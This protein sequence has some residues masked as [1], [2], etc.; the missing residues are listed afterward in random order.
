M[1]NKLISLLE[2]FYSLALRYNLCI[3]N[4]W[5]N[6]RLPKKPDLKQRKTNIGIKILHIILDVKF[7]SFLR[8][9]IPPW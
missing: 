9:H 6:K 1:F 2:Y 7:N 3:K 8:K 4:S 5:S